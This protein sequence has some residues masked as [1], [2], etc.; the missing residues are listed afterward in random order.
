MSTARRCACGRRHL[1][2]R[3]GCGMPTQCGQLGMRRFDLRTEV[4]CLRGVELVE[5]GQRLAPGAGCGIDA[6]KRLLGVAQVDQN[7][8]LVV[9]RAEVAENAEGIAVTPHRLG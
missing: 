4:L 1:W 7:Q 9:L 2:L 8:R 3:V 5:Y 6:A